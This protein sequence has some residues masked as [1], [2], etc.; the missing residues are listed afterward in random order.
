MSENEEGEKKGAMRKR[1][2]CVGGQ[3]FSA[4]KKH[5]EK[6]EK[7]KPFLVAF[8]TDVRRRRTN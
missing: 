6:E 5:R 4:V 8:T 2:E 3:V 7:K 1:R